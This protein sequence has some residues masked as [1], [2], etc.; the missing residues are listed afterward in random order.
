MKVIII[1]N[2]VAGGRKHGKAW[3]A[4]HGAFAAQFP[5]LEVHES[6][7]SGDAIRLA[8]VEAERG[9]DLII[10][11]GGDGTISDV[12]HGVLTSARPNTPLAFLPIGTGCDFVRNFDLP[13]DPAEIALRIAEAVPRKIDAGLLLARDAEGREQRRYF[14]NI[15]SVGISGEIVDA[16]NAPGRAKILGGPLRFLVFSVLAILKYRPYAFDIL[17][18]GMR[19]HEGRLAIAAIANGAWFG[20]GMHV[21][22][23]ADLAD[24]LFNIAVMREE[25]VIGLLGLLKSLYSAGHVGHPLLSFHRG[26]RIELRPQDPNRFPVEVDGESPIRGGFVAEIVPGALT[27]RT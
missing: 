5:G 3:H 14:A 1:R 15:A 8:R 19:V 11:A 20:G 24:G 18:D 16:V 10:V 9:C 12:V 13:K 27:I 17:V 2:P 22:P 26:R 21:T 23:Q 7:S 6:R 25:T 4:A